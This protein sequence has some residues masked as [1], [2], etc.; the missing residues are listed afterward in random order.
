MKL[1]ALRLQHTTIHVKLQPLSETPCLL[2]SL[3][4]LM[5]LTMEQE[6]LAIA[7]R[8]TFIAKMKDIFEE[9]ASLNRAFQV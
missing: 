8:A 6:A 1:Y 3:K 4:D 7:L 5:D 9:R 2:L